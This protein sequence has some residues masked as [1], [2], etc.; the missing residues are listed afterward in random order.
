MDVAVEPVLKL[1]EELLVAIVKSGVPRGGG[2]G[3][4]LSFQAVRG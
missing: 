4:L 3:A 1:R 2:G